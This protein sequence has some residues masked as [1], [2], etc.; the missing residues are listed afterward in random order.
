MCVCNNNNQPHTVPVAVSSY[1][2]KRRGRCAQPLRP[3]TRAAVPEE[4]LFLRNL[5]PFAEQEWTTRRKAVS[6]AGH[7][8][9]FA[10]FTI[11]IHT[12]VRSTHTASVPP[13]N[14]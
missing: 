11:G 9:A 10:R 4:H 8:D 13:S 1:R 3:G 14:R 2:E 7:D 12:R 6:K 5:Y